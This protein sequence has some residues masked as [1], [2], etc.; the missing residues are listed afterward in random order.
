MSSV[1]ENVAEGAGDAVAR[2][3]VPADRPAFG[4]D[5]DLGR[6]ATGRGDVELQVERPGE[7]AFGVAALF[8][9]EPVFVL[10]VQ[11]WRCRSG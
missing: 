11:D 7:R 4:V 8:E 2:F 10:Q 1:P 5:L 6:D 3:G 9:Y